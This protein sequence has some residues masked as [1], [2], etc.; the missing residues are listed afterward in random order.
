MK[1]NIILVV[2]CLLALGVGA[3]VPWDTTISGRWPHYY[4]T[5]ALEDEDSGDT[6]SV[7]SS[8]P[9]AV[10]VQRDSLHSDWHG[11]RC[12][13]SFDVA[14]EFACLM[15]CDSTMH[16]V[17]VAFVPGWHLRFANDWSNNMPEGTELTATIYDTG[18]RVLN[19]GTVTVDDI[20]VGPF[21][22]PAYCDCIVGPF[23]EVYFNDTIELDAPFYVS[24][25]AR[26][27]DTMLLSPT[28]YVM[29]D[30][31][32]TDGEYECNYPYEQR[33]YRISEGDT[34][35]DEMCGYNH[36]TVAFP[37]LAMK[38][39][40]VENLHY[41][42]VGGAGTMAHVQWSSDIL[43]DYYEVSYGPAGT[44]PGEGT[45]IQT[46]Q[47]RIVLSPLDRNTRYDVYVRARCDRDTSGWT[48]WSDALQVHLA[49][50][51]VDDVEAMHWSLT[52]NPAHGSATVQCNE[53]IMSVE[54]LTLKGEVLSR[55]ETA[56]V[57]QYTIDLA[58]L[59]KGMYIVRIA[60]PHG[61]ATRKLAV[62]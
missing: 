14:K 37:I 5:Y 29:G 39:Y 15:Q 3:Q 35:H 28:L 40:E 17:G 42:P 36:L 44:P 62:E 41:E 11:R 21:W 58:G 10:F 32:G 53:G 43:H 54:L 49:T 23:M 7:Y 13:P 4:Y 47:R 24:V 6:W 9:A 30:H 57:H 33:R 8:T 38:C 46:T 12:G 52:P 27:H 60:T 59:A 61:T 1:K 2:L 20:D 16:V 55:R 31:I 48:S 50:Y 26:H 25:T 56:G 22:A 18:M 45:V 51:G 34:W 19:T